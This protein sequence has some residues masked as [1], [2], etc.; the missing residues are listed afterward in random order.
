ME[1]TLFSS[2]QVCQ[3]S[4]LCI[5]KNE[6]IKKLISKNLGD[7]LHI[8][9]NVLTQTICFRKEKGKCFAVAKLVPFK[10]LNFGKNEFTM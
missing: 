3:T 7:F 10:M 8:T 2:E 6:G 1:F 9:N 4:S 5:V